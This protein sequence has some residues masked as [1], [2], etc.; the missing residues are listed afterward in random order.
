M[1]PREEIHA[2]RVRRAAGCAGRA[3]LLILPLGLALSGVRGQAAQAQTST[4]ALSCNAAL[5]SLMAEW[6]AIGYSEPGKP[7]QMI[8]SGRHGY[9][10]T[11]GRI[12][13]LRQRIGSGARDCEA[14]REQEA[15]RNIG[16]A[17]EI[18]AGKGLAVQFGD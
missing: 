5:S 12:R 2:S 13:Y 17:H 3:A 14:G 4:P 10:T 15:M 18:L 7:S 9:T 1:R 16:A 11:A 6:K 8:V